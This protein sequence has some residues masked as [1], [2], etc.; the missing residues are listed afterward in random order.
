M[1][2]DTAV[3]LAAI[4]TFLTKKHPKSKGQAARQQ[5]L[6]KFSQSKRRAAFKQALLNV[7]PIQDA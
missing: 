1:L 6:S 3:G 4:S 2:Y 7:K 5:I